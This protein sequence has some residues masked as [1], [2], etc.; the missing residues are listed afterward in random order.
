MCG[1]FG[2][3]SETEIDVKDLKFIASHSK[4]RGIDSSGVVTFRKSE[5]QVSRADFEIMKLLK[6]VKWQDSK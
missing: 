6:N 1:I 5:Y 3:I 4:Q 2:V